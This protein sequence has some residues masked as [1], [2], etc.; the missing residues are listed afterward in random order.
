MRILISTLLILVTPVLLAADGSGNYAIWGS[1]NKS[2][3][4]YNLTR[5]AGE[6]APF[7]DYLMGY[8][9]AY[10]HQAEDTYSISRDM[11]LSEIMG[12]LDEECELKPVIAFEEAIINFL[13]EHYEDRMKFPPGGF[14]Q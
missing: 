13:V 8:L 9:T 4:K 14:G 10:N 1:G 11:N 5:A 6:D 3:H 12:W 2:C 7:R